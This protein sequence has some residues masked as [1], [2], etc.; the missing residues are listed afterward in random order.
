MKPIRLDAT[1]PDSPLEQPE[2]LPP[3]TPRPTPAGPK[4]GV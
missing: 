1:V 2:R 3:T 4:A